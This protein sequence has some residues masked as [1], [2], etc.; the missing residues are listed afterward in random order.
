MKGKPRI[1]TFL[2]LTYRYFW[3]EAP[4]SLLLKEIKTSQEPYDQQLLLSFYNK[5]ASFNWDL[6]LQNKSRTEILS[7]KSAIPSFTVK[8]LL[9][10]M[11]YDSIA[12]NIQAMDERAR[13]GFLF[14]RGNNLIEPTGTILELVTGI[15]KEFKNIGIKAKPDEDFPELLR[16]HTQ[17]KSKI[18]QSSFYKQK[19]VLFQDKA[20]YSAI[21]LLDPQPN[22]VICDLCAAPGIKTQLIAQH[23]N[24]KAIITAGD[25][26]YDRTHEM[27]SVLR[28]YGVKNVH[29]I[30]WDGIQSPLKQNFFDKI[31]LDAPC[32]GSGTFTSNPVLKWRQTRKFLTRNVFLQER[33][34]KNALDLLKVGGSLVYS[35]CSLYPEEGEH[36]IEKISEETI[37][38]EDT[39][40]WL[41]SSYE[42]NNN[43]LEGSG[44]FS[45]ANDHTI[46]FFVSKMM[47]IGK[48]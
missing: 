28:S 35:T 10:V 31:L 30:Q 2:Y 18:V 4:I 16:V 12:M 32:T 11:D 9:P 41:P 8:T 44:R 29:S 38:F 48:R 20:S 14:L 39:P 46:G 13:N 22:D 26:H 37:K 6:A 21:S 27:V 3:E 15:I 17:D 43:I 40:S 5:L 33:L 45:P 7:I 34:L 24:N 19:I 42:C 47:K 36:Q 25:F 23:T 1:E